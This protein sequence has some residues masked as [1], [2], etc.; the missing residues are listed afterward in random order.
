MM[1]E[2]ELGRIQIVL[3]QKKHFKGHSFFQLVLFSK[4]IVATDNKL[5]RQKAHM[6]KRRSHS[7][8]LN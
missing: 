1:R 4:L 2:S 7:E 5:L 3:G 8:G 6:I